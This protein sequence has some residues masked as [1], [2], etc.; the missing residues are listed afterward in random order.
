M[1]VIQNRLNDSSINEQNLL[2]T[3]QKVIADFDKGESEL[4]VRLVDKNEIQ[5]LNKT[6]RHKNQP[7][8]VLSFPSDLPKEI[9]ES[10]LGDVIIC[11]EVVR[12]EAQT[13][14]KTFEHHLTH[15]SIHGVL[16]L[17]GYN[18]IKNSEAKTME[19]LEIKIL[20]ELGID[21]PY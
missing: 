21:N 11:I 13:Q 20:S 10:I 4:L 3:L 7:T 15:I 9:T 16:H 8:N 18:H 2:N 5:T 1:V 19:S 6:Y 14:G 17:L 12:E